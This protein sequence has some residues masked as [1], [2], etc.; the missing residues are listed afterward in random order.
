MTSAD[1]TG[2]VIGER[3]TEIDLIIDP[4]K[5]ARLSIS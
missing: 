3:I 5:L 1:S 2:A 4:A